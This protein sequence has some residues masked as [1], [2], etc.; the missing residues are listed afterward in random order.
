M[1]QTC[2]A[3]GDG[4]NEDFFLPWHRMFVYYFELIVRYVTSE[5][6]STLPY[7]NYSN[8]AQSALPPE[9][10]DKSSPLFRSNR[11]PNINRGD[12]IPATDTTLEA[13]KEPLYSRVGD[14]PGFCEQ[15]DLSIHGNVHTDVGDTQGMAAIPWAAKD[16]IFWLHHCNIDRLWAS[17]DRHN[18]KNPTYPAWLNQ[19][20]V[21]ADIHGNMV[22][23]EVEDFTTTLLLGYTYQEFEPEPD[24]CPVPF[25]ILPEVLAQVTLI[26]IPLSEAP[27]RLPLQV[28]VLGVPANK[29]VYLVFR[30]VRAESAPGVLYDV[31]L[32]L[33]WRVTP[34]RE[35]ASYI[36]PM[37]FFG[38]TMMHHGRDIS[39][40]VTEKLNSLRDD[41]KLI[42]TLSVI[43]VPRG[44]L[45][46]KARPVIGQ[47]QLVAQ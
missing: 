12:Q 14:A 24:V 9:F 26:D 15:L 37:N 41:G 21:F 43:I 46:Q 39:F 40:E 35:S 17:W 27:I 11:W 45:D 44:E 8:P 33:P 19:E 28:R 6:S 38:L 29:V 5:P 20:F 1:W 30:N 3:H 7:W 47:I 25:T 31:Y 36:A 10:L 32:D 2:Q 13:F 42:P 18:C 4:D 23:A 34:S 16:P 22:V